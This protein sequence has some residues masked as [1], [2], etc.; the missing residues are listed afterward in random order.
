MARRLPLL[1]TITAAALALASLAVAASSSE[2]YKFKAQLNIGQEVPKPTGTKRGASGRFTATL[3]EKGNSRK[4]S[5]RLT[6]SH[7]SGPAQ[8]AHIHLGKRG[9]AGP[10]AVTLCGPCSSGIYK[11]TA[12]TEKV[13]SALEKG[14]AYV[15]VHTPK[16]PSGEIRGQVTSSS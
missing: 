11:T 16:N 7:L 3:V 15:N 2:T 13:A 1:L 10:V 8:A 14:R 5:W 4:L 6:F 9:K 12:V